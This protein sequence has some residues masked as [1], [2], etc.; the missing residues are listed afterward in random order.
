M[1]LIPFL[2]AKPGPSNTSKIVYFAA[3]GIVAVVGALAAVAA[4]T[5]H[6]VRAESVTAIK[7]DFD[8]DILASFDG[9][10]VT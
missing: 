8:R 5:T 1:A 10:P 9:P 2:T 6:K 7:Q 3:L 4:L